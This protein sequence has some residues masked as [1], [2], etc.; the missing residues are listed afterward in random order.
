MKYSQ[1]PTSLI[2]SERFV[3]P[4]QMQPY[5]VRLIAESPNA[6][7]YR[8]NHNEELWRHQNV[9]FY[10]LNLD[11]IRWERLFSGHWFVY[12]HGVLIYAPLFFYEQYPVNKQGVPPNSLALMVTVLAS[13]PDVARVRTS[14][15]TQNI[16]T[17]VCRNFFHSLQVNAGIWSQ[18]RPRPL[19]SKPESQLQTALINIP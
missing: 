16:Q 1:Q 19:P 6:L 11:I 2:F 17:E 3:G 14:A 7:Y 15:G 18:V 10:L 4:N 5:P 8:F 13:P 12:L 9:M